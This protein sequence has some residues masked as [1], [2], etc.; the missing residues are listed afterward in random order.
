ML[1][2][3]KVLVVIV[4]STILGT[5]LAIHFMLILRHGGENLI[6]L[7]SDGSEIFPLENLDLR[8]LSSCS[9]LSACP[10]LHYVNVT[11]SGCT[12]PSGSHR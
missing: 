4:C 11:Y 12:G 8:I 6:S 9:W 2:K 10:P 1:N 3:Y 5:S 7:T